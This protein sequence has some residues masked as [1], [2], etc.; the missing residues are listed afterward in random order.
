MRGREQADLAVV[1]ALKGA[2]PE[3]QIELPVKQQRQLRPF[4]KME[5]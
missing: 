2:L 4:R 3:G 1:A 5:G